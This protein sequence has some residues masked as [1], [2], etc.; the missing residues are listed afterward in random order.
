MTQSFVEQRKSKAPTPSQTEEEHEAKEEPTEEDT[1]DDEVNIVEKIEWVSLKLKQKL[2][3]LYDICEWQFQN[4]T[5]LRAN[6][7]FEDEWATWVCPLQ[8][9]IDPLTRFCSASNPLVMML[10]IT[11]IIYLPGIDFGSTEHH[12]ENLGSPQKSRNLLPLQ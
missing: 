8:I 7:K 11:R 12:P 3:V 5:R 6:M 4:P 10:H 2:D 1:P 9:Q